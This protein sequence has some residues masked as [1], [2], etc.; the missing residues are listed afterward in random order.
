MDVLMDVFCAAAAAT[1]LGLACAFNSVKRQDALSYEVL[2]RYWG[3][4]NALNGYLPL[5]CEWAA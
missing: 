5:L 3:L 2:G 1:Y 4:V